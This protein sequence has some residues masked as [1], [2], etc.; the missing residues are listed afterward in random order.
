MFLGN[1][2]IYEKGKNKSEKQTLKIYTSLGSEFAFVF[3]FVFGSSCEHIISV[4]S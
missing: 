2:W 4:N 3:A 1:I